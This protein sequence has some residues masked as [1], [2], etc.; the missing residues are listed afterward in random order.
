MLV[1]SIAHDACRRL[2]LTGG[3]GGA[4]PDWPAILASRG[5]EAYTLPHVVLG[6]P[7]FAGSLGAQVARTGAYGQLGELLDGSAN[8]GLDLPVPGIS[9]PARDLVER[10]LARRG[11]AWVAETDAAGRGVAFARAWEDARGRARELADLAQ[12]VRLG[13]AA[14]FPGKIDTACALLSSGTSRCVTLDTGSGSLFWDTHT[15]NDPR[16]SPLWEGLFEGLARLMES[17]AATPGVNAPTLLGETCVV[18]LSEMGRTPRRNATLGKDHWP[19]T[20]AMLLGSGFSGGRTLGAVGDGLVGLPIDPL[21][22][23][24]HPAGEVLSASTLGATLL[25]MGDVDPA[26][27]TEAPTLAL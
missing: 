2:L 10:F 20:S 7:S 8:E 23:R 13:Q 25:A 18:V 14:D 26:E 15:D 3:A 11:P 6:G 4:T 22:G 27:W 17:L 19:Y 16:Q 1:R 5:T 12:E 9:A 21:T 24:G